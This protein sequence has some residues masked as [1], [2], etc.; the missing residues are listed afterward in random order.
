M[1]KKY[2]SIN[3]FDLTFSPASCANMPPKQRAAKIIK[4]GGVPHVV[5]G[6]EAF[7]LDT[8][9]GLATLEREVGAVAAISGAKESATQQAQ[10][11]AME[12]KA[13]EARRI[14]AIDEAPEKI[15]K[16]ENRVDKANLAINDVD[17]ALNSIDAFTTGVLG[18]VLQIKPAS[19][20]RDLDSLYETLRSRLGIESLGEMREE[21]K[22]GS[23]GFGQL[24]ELELRGI[25]S[26][27]S[28]LDSN[29]TPEQQVR[30]LNILRRH[31]LRQ[32]AIAVNIAQISEGLLTEEQGQRQVRR[33]WQEID[34]RF[35]TRRG[36]DNI[37]VQ[38]PLNLEGVSSEELRKA[39]G[40]D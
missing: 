36:E 35:K 9:E 28:A 24:N 6:E 16:A 17:L 38:E 37:G 22:D 10:I 32:R 12:P 4:I 13:V 21:S 11:D 27:V 1:I 7:P 23:S 30:N 20:R 19:D 18:W 8:P 2:K 14:A 34:D 40:L 31:I 39:A 15:V 33:D 25:Q 3:R 5:S 29:L 26:A